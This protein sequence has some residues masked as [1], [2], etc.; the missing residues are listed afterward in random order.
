MAITGTSRNSFPLWTPWMVTWVRKWW[1]ARGWNINSGWLI[2]SHLPR[3]WIWFLQV[4]F[5]S[6]KNWFKMK[7]QFLSGC[8][9]LWLTPGYFLWLNL[10]V[11]LKS[12]VTWL[13]LMSC[14][15]SNDRTR[16]RVCAP[17]TPIILRL[18]SLGVV[19]RKLSKRTN[20]G[21]YKINGVILWR[22]CR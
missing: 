8:L 9:H 13:R 6:N 3:K 21:R 1:V 2:P 18:S 12:E 16:F 11:N 14:Q 20:V 19:H 17:L 15:N 5:L 10:S 7:R 22:F 4:S